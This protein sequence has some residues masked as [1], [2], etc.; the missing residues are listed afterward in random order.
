MSKRKTSGRAL[1]RATKKLYAPKLDQIELFAI[2]NVGGK[3]TGAGR[4][5]GEG[6]V[7]I[8]VPLT[9]LPEIQQ[10]ISNYKNLKSVTEIK[11]LN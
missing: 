9:C 5:V 7:T 1:T 2:K 6:S 3:R 10:I 4:P 11:L 8:R